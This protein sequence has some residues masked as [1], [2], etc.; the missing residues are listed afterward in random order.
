MNLPMTKMIGQPNAEVPVPHPLFRAPAEVGFRDTS[1]PKGLKSDVK[2]PQGTGPREIPPSPSWNPRS[3]GD[4]LHELLYLG[5]PHPDLQK[6]LK[7]AR[8]RH[9]SGIIP[10]TQGKRHAQHAGRV[11]GRELLAEE[12][13]GLFELFHG[14]QQVGQVVDANHGIR[15]LVPQLEAPCGPSLAKKTDFLNQSCKGKLFLC[16]QL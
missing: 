14:L 12:F 2:W 13:F 1:T 9:L 4:L 16:Y 3:L 5:R 8:G 15:V 7:F 11:A 10:P 6:T